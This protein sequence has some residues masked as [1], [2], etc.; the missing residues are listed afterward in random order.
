MPDRPLLTPYIK[1]NGSKKSL[2]KII[3]KFYWS[4][5]PGSTVVDLFCGSGAMTFGV[6]PEKA[7]LI[8]GN[9]EL[10]NLHKQIAAQNFTIIDHPYAEE[11]YSEYYEWFLQKREAFNSGKIEDP[12][13]RASVLFALAHC[14][15]NGLF[16][17]SGRSTFNCP[18]GYKRKG[19]PNEVSQ[20]ARE[21]V[22]NNIFWMQDWDYRVAHFGEG[23]ELEDSWGMTFP[24][25][26]L[27]YAD[28]PY[29][30]V[31]SDKALKYFPGGD[32]Y[33]RDQ[34][35]LAALIAQEKRPAMLSNEDF[36][37]MRDMFAQH[38]LVCFSYTR[39]NCISSKAKT[40]GEE[41]SELLAINQSLQQ[42]KYIDFF[43]KY[44]GEPV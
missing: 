6:N 17:G 36:P 12:G 22:A 1:Y 41:R 9:E 18:P 4:F 25:E 37:A 13:E 40:R 33:D 43:V 23:I 8:D 44:F 35:R 30:K 26:S 27:I 7:M 5:F 10:I 24:E 29:A 31:N 3:R 39:S 14:G 42:P 20:K 28:P 34:S 19:V 15:Y 2:A 32:F 38:G 11:T 21:A 16:R